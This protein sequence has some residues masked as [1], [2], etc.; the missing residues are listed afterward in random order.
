[1]EPISAVAFIRMQFLACFSGETWQTS[2]GEDRTLDEFLAG[3]GVRLPA[4]FFSYSGFV[5]V[6]D[7]IRE[8]GRCMQRSRSVTVYLMLRG[9]MYPTA[10]RFADYMNVRGAN[11]FK[12][13]DGE[14]KS[15]ILRSGD[16]TRL[17]LEGIPAF[18]LLFTIN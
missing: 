3:Q 13:L 5:A 15:I 17:Q 1:M 16:G 4:A 12:D 6:D 9:D 14:W 2:I 11:Q 7:M 10:E 8:D 18:E